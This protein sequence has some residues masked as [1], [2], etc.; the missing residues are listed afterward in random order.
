VQEARAQAGSPVESPPMTP[1]RIAHTESSLGWGGQEIRILSEAQGMIARGHAVTL[2]CPPEAR[3]HEEASRYGVPAVGLPIGRKR[4]AGLRALHAWFGAHPY[5]VV[6][7]H[8]STDSWLAALAL[9]ALGRP[10]PLVRTR[11]ISA[12]VPKGR[13]TRWLYER[14]ARRVVTTGESLRRRLVEENG[15][16]ANCIVSIPTGVDTAIFFPSDKAQARAR[17]GLPHERRLVGIVATL[18]SWKGHAFLVEALVRLP[19]DVVLVIVGNGPGWEPL[20]AQV[21]RLGL[22]ARVVFAG[23]QREVAPWFQALDVFVLP[24]YANEGVP[25][26]ILQAMACALPVISTPVGAIPEVLEDGVDGLMIPA[27]DAAA[28]ASAVSRLLGDAVLAARLGGE[29]R[30]RVA[31]RHS[32]EAMLDGMERVFL[33]AAGRGLRTDHSGSPS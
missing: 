17:L 22:R 4:V 16:S 33:E 26:A 32:R 13:L 24:S 29:A 3:I 11:H 7:T 28:I 9:L 18:R 6:N 31:G 2:L 5:D 1:L 14:A 30:A 27:K 20:H 10:F 25:Q 12:A 21:E 23:E 8:S 19:E 15:F